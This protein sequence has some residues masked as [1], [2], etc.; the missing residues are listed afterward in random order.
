MTLRWL[1]IAV[2]LAAAAP[3]TA[4]RGRAAAVAAA[5]VEPPPVAGMV[6][7]SPRAPGERLPLL[8][9]LHG[10]GDSGDEAW[11]RLGLAAFGQRHRAFVVALDGTP[12]SRG[13]KFWNAG[14]ACCNFDGR[15]VDDVARITA[16]IDRWRARPDVDPR[17]I[18]VAG[19][20]NGG[21]MAHRLAC[22][23]GDR[24]AA[25]ASTGGAGPPASRACTLASP[26]GVLEVH[27]DADR[28]VRYD[29][30]RVF[31][32]PTSEPYASA[33]ETLDTWAQR[34]GCT[35]EAA[36]DEPAGDAPPLHI[37]RR[38]PCARGDVELWTIP[39]GGHGIVS[40]ALLE[41]IWSFLSAHAKP[42][43]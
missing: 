5:G 15:G 8:I 2:A 42:A 18:Y 10:Y 21:F 4:C 14:G 31:D 36:A 37:Q 32:R 19:H 34:L 16:L 23:I 40:P 13:R 6:E 17:R 27:G 41:R 30:G 11:G 3:A 29:G 38:A 35:A 12:D 22:A 24:L 1:A 43:R 9:F 25:V 7:P 28:I 20:S 39:G 26:I 33:R